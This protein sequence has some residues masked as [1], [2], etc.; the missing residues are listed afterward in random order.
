MQLLQLF[1]NPGATAK[2]RAAGVL[3]FGD[4]ATELMRWRDQR[5]LSPLPRV[6]V[7][8]GSL[9]LPWREQLAEE[10][11]E[12]TVLAWGT[13]DERRRQQL[14][15]QGCRVLVCGVGPD[16]EGGSLVEALGKE[17]RTIYSVAGPRVLSALIRSGH[18]DRLYLT[19]AQLV[20]GGDDFD[21]LSSGPYFDP[22]AAFSLAELYLDTTEPDGNGQLIAVFDRPQT[23]G[24]GPG[25][26]WRA[27][28]P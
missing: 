21:T 17:C 20:L 10:F 16:V 27:A 26:S 19:L 11:G 12:I 22:P 5:G 23:A 13:V 9:R 28:R 24:Y 4:S 8:S 6:V 15:E 3:G 25:P 18:L 2:G 1:P 7:I 14:Q